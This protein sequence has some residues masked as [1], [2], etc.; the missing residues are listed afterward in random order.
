MPQ[1]L[2]MAMQEFSPACRTTKDH[3]EL[4]KEILGLFLPKFLMPARMGHYLC[5]IKDQ[6]GQL[7]A[8]VDLSLQP[9]SGTLDAL[10]PMTVSQR[11]RKYGKSQLEPYLCN[12]LVAKEARGQGLGKQMIERCKE[13][14]ARDGFDSINL[15]CESQPSPALRLYTNN[16]FVPVRK[17]NDGKLLF[18]RLKGVD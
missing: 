2:S 13:L 10:T 8:F 5:G 1:I 14:A 16:D 12:L 3:T 17:M 11:E 9:N 4:I 6:N 15:H 7:V 18:M